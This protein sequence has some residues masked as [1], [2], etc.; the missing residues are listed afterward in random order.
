MSRLLPFWVFLGLFGPLRPSVSGPYPLPGLSA[1]RDIFSRPTIDM[2]IDIRRIYEAITVDMP[3][4][5]GH[6]V[7]ETIHMIPRRPRP[8]PALPRAL[9]RALPVFFSTVFFSTVFLSALVLL[10]IGAGNASADGPA[11]GPAGEGRLALSY[12]VSVDGIHALRARIEIDRRARSYAGRFSARLEGLPS[13]VSDLHVDARA[14]G[15]RGT[16]GLGG[17]GSGEA[18]AFL[19]VAYTSRWADKKGVRTVA[20]RF[21]PPQRRQAVDDPE[22]RQA[23]VETTPPA[24]EDGRAVVPAA[25]IIGAVDPLTV[26]AALL[27]EVDASGSCDGSHAVFDGRR[28]FHLRIHPAPG[29]DED[30]AGEDD[31]AILEGE[32]TVLRCRVDLAKVAGFTEKERR[33]RRLPDH[34]V[35]SFAPGPTGALVPTRMEM[36]HKAGRV[37]V[38][39][40]GAD[41]QKPGS[42]GRAA[43]DRKAT[44]RA[45]GR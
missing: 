42:E 24:A 14:H 11:P 40:S 18:T 34:I 44:R 35:V 27:Q 16:G 30:G 19:P 25:R 28:L 15:I 39:L 22:R 7:D 2:T 21:D 12:K 45:G 29:S 3:D 26:L 32:T 13:W 23:V 43:D 6:A 31:G 17:A 4:P 38:V 1:G 5:G 20:I 9:P 36:D 41:A 37:R 8:R 33:G 10:A